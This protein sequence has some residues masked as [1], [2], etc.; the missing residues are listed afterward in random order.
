MLDDSMTLTEYRLRPFELL[1]MQERSRFLQIPRRVYLET[2]WESP[3]EIHAR[4]NDELH[5]VDDIKTRVRI[6]REVKVQQELQRDFVA[7][8]MSNPVDET[9][10][11]PRGAAALMLL[12]WKNTPEARARENEKRRR[13]LLQR[14]EQE[15]KKRQQREIEDNAMERWVERLVIIEGHHLN[16]WKNRGDDSPEQSWDLRRVVEV[17]GIP[18][19]PPSHYSSLTLFRVGPKNQPEFPPDSVAAAYAALKNSNA[20]NVIRVEAKQKCD[21]EEE[22]KA[23]RPHLELHIRFS[24]PLSSVNEEFNPTGPAAKFKREF[25]KMIKP[26]TFSTSAAFS[27]LPP[28][29][30]DPFNQGVG[31]ST[32]EGSGSATLALRLPDE[33]CT[34]LTTVFL[35]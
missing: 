30:S 4:D 15:E 18:S 10:E 24:I 9:R 20:L 31:T 3:A 32:I 7:E 25:K 28:N 5:G 19:S 33:L 11:E 2:Y 13:K 16:V 1:E 12:S 23:S 34:S 21:M 6:E 22:A 27:R 35:T 29:S 8:F 14:A 17:S 26:S